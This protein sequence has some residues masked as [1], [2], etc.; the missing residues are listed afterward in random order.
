LSDWDIATIRFQ[1]FDTEFT[2]VIVFIRKSQI[3]NISDVIL[4]HPHHVLVEL[5]VLLLHV[6]IGYRQAQD[7][8]VKGWC[9]ECLHYETIVHGLADYPADE[10]K[11]Y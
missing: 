4:N 11:K 7:M 5:V 10:L 9:E 3:E 1:V 2:K 8:L 6:A